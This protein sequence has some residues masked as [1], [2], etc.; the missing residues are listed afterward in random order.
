MYLAKAQRRLAGLSGEMQGL[1][2][3]LGLCDVQITHF[4][5]IACLQLRTKHFIY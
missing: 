4:N 2:F 3:R 1:I 5:E